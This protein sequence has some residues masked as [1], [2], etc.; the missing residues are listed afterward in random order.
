MLQAFV[1]DSCSKLQQTLTT[2]SAGDTSIEDGEMEI[3]Y[4]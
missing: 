1:H 2:L 4:I 3:I